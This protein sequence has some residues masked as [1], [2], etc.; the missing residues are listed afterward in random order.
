MVGGGLMRRHG[1]YQQNDNILSL[2]AAILV[3]ECCT[4]TQMKIFLNSSD[5]RTARIY[6]DS[7]A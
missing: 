2:P 6:V 5:I 1:A 7:T 4:L 3:G